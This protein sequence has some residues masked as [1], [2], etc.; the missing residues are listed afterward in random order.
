MDRRSFIALAGAFGAAACAARPAA[1][2]AAAP[3]AAGAAVA[4]P[5][6]ATAERTAPGMVRL[7][8]SGAAGPVRVLASSDPDAPAGLMRVLAEAD[9]DGVHDVALAA[10]PRP[11]FLIEAEAGRAAR[12]AE[13]VLPLQ[14]GRNFRDLGG[15]VGEGGRPVRWGRIYRSGVTA[16]LTADDLSYLSS[17]GVRT[18]CDFRSASERA[19]E[20]SRL[21]GAAGVTFLA[22]DYELDYGAMGGILGAKTRDE[23][24]AGFAASYVDFAETLAPQLSDMF[25]Q[26]IRGEAPLAFN[27]TAGKDRTGLAA[28][29]V[30]SALGVD[31]ATVVADYALSETIVPPDTYLAALR[32]EGEAAASIGAAERAMFA[33]LPEEV[34]RV[35]LGSP[36]G[37]IDRPEIVHLG[38]GD[39]EMDYLRA[40]YLA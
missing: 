21:D 17:L 36:S 14:G 13:R 31:R 5:L 19:R 1:A 25:R 4:G 40:V 37:E 8:W 30:L 23:A 11:Y 3:S 39:A 32:G 27:C 18:V 28:A 24:I 6:A 22:R 10:D 38:G 16:G 12:T 26:L 35:L 34:A 33:N 2:P 9:A 29:L 15:Y 20:A 7:A